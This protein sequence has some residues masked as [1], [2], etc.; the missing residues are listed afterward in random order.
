MATVKNIDWRKLGLVCR[1][2]RQEAR[3][4]QEEFAKK[5]GHTQQSISRFESGL[6]SFAIF[7]YMREYPAIVDEITG[8]I[9]GRDV[10][11]FP[12]VFD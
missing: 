5:Y 9:L 8:Q 1:H 4:T 7:D 12:V 2:A 10:A 6:K 11:V 3:T